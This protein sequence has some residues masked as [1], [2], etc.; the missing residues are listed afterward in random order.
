MPPLTRFAALMAK[1]LNKQRMQLQCVPTARFSSPDMFPAVRR[2]HVFVQN[3]TKNTQMA[4]VLRNASLF[5]IPSVPPRRYQWIAGSIVLFVA[6][7]A[8]AASSTPLKAQRSVRVDQVSPPSIPLPPLSF[9]PLRCD[10]LGS[11]SPGGFESRR[12]DIGYM[13]TDEAAVVVKRLT[14]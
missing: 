14:D 12:E 4:D 9:K 8:A 11:S 2:L 13:P 7:V 1:L 3:S 5:T 10:A 6:A